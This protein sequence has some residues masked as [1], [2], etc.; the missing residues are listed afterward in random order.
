MGDYAVE[1]IADLLNES[2]RLAGWLQVYRIVCYLYNMDFLG[3]TFAGWGD[4]M[5]RISTGALSI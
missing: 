5:N 3:C 2:T 1:G 4:D